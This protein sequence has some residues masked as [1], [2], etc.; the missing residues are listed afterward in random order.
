MLQLI[1]M[2][3]T[4]PWQIFDAA[5]TRAESGISDDVRSAI[6]ML[7]TIVDDPAMRHDALGNRAWLYRSIGDYE[8][9][10]RD[11]DVLAAEFP[12]DEDIAVLTAE[13]DLMN[14]NADK[15]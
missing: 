1:E 8:S 10:R 2:S 11:Y 9:A 14:G 5:R 13:L 7:G 12:E 15:A 3:T 6:D 4:T